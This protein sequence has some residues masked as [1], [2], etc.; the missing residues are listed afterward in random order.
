[1]LASDVGLLHGGSSR[2]AAHGTLSEGSSGDGCPENPST[3]GPVPAADQACTLLVVLKDVVEPREFC[4]NK[5]T[6]SPTSVNVMEAVRICTL[7]YGTNNLEACCAAYS[8][9]TEDSVVDSVEFDSA[10]TTAAGD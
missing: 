5:V 9:L 10:M 1:M 7:H 6:P 4:E 8:S 2:Y 3:G